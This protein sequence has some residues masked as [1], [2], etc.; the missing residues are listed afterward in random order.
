MRRLFSL[1]CGKE[2]KI[3]VDDWYDNGMAAPWFLQPVLTLFSG[4]KKASVTPSRSARWLACLLPLICAKTVAAQEEE[5]PDRC[6]TV[7]SDAHHMVATLCTATT[8]VLDQF[9]RMFTSMCGDSLLYLRGESILPGFV[10]THVGHNCNGEQT[11]LKMVI[12]GVPECL[13]ENYIELMKMLPD[14][15]VCIDGVT[16]G[17]STLGLLLAGVIV[18]LVTIRARLSGHR[19]ASEPLRD[20]PLLAQQQLGVIMHAPGRHGGRLLYAR[21]LNVSDITEVD[22]DSDS[23]SDAPV[24]IDSTQSSEGS[25]L[26]SP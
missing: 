19:E 13:L 1:F 5:H 2:R 6:F 18:V 25:S 10:D 9:Y 17:L 16:V 11:I 23:D 14:N 22:A 7:A 24:E 4:R 20:I 26:L 21:P 15:P 3:N 12:P 8:D